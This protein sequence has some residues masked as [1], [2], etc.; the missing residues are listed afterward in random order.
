MK[1]A[2]VK[3]SKQIFEKLKIIKI[4]RMSRNSK[5]TLHYKWV[6]GDLALLSW[7]NY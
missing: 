7:E 1:L 4:G 2:L 3:R 5:C 6:I